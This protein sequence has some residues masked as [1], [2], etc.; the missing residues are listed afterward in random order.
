[1]MNWLR[2]SCVLVLLTSLLP[3]QT[4]VVD[5]GGVVTAASFT[6]PVAPGALISIFGVNLAPQIAAASQIPLP[7]SLANVSVRFNNNVFAPLLFVSPTQVNAQL[8]WEV[9]S[10]GNVT[11]VVTNNGVD[12]APQTVPVSSFSPAIFAVQ[13]NAIAIH[14]DVTLVAPKTAPA[15][16]G[17]T[18]Q[19]LTTGL[20]PVPPPPVTAT[21]S[22][23]CL[24][25]TPPPPTPFFPS[26]P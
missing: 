20:G 14:A 2:P 25:N 4:P 12:S 10:N 15:V 17:E 7:T 13:G 3:A 8:P 5:S 21:N 23:H 9:V 19:L 26:A 24:R 22:L 1:M 6:A 16:P 11:L 18:L